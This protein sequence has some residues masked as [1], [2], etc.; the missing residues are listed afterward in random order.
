MSIWSPKFWKATAERVIVGFAAGALGTLGT[1]AVNVLEVDLAQAG[2][3]GLGAALVTLLASIVASGT[4][5]TLSLA[6]AEV[7]TVA[8]VEKA[9]GSV[10]VAGPANT[11]VKPGSTVRSL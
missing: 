6:G 7:P 11:I 1:G 3:V 8:V 4:T 9:Q 5:G 2:A 10:V